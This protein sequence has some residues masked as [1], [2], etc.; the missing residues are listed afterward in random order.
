MINIGFAQ[1]RRNS[2]CRARS[3]VADLQR[4]S[5]G[6]GVGVA[7]P[8]LPRASPIEKTDKQSLAT[9]MTGAGF[10]YV[11]YDFVT[12]LE[13]MESD[14]TA[15]GVAT[16]DYVKQ[17]GLGITTQPD[18]PL[19]VFGAGPQNAAY[20]AGLPASDQVAFKRALWGEANDW[21]HARARLLNR[22]T[23]P[24]RWRGYVNPADKRV[25]QDPR[26]IAALKKWSECMRAKGFSFDTPD[27]VEADLRE[28]LA[29]IVGGREVT[30]LTGSALAA[31]GQLQGEER[32]V[33]TV[34]TTCEEKH[35]ES[36]QEKVE[37]DIL[38]AAPK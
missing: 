32:A 28:R 25:T 9:C 16:E 2:R 36:V 4:R 12:I 1:D 15:K 19:V 38:D 29:G 21:N 26:M 20:L 31:L 6:H 11:A 37:S 3:R 22:P 33:A 24:T 27:Q 23:R 18:K 10:R 17:F 13:A 30:A 14:K 7:S 34:L 35:I 5:S 8:W